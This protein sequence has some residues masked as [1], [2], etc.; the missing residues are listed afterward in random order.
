MSWTAPKTFTANSTLTAADL[1]TFLRDNFSQTVPAIAQTPEAMYISSGL[2]S[3]VERV[4][5]GGFVAATETT[6]TARYVNL[7]TVGPSVTVTSG[8]SALVF[9]SANIGNNTANTGTWMSYTVSGATTAAAADTTAL[10][11]QEM[12]GYAVGA[13]ILHNGLTAGSNTFTC[14]YGVSGGTGTFDSRRISVIPL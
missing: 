4:P 2:N 7:A 8:T 14:K 10:L 5:T 1:N 9:L 13:A 3:V 6:T 11:V 12:T